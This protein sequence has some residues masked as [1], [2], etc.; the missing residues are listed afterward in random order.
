MLD[1]TYR[2]TH[3]GLS[4]DGSTQ[5]RRSLTHGRVRYRLSNRHRQTFGCKLP[6]LNG[7]RADTQISDTPPPERLI[8]KMRDEN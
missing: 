3:T 1:L 6:A 7:L 2:L 4:A 8:G 5:Q